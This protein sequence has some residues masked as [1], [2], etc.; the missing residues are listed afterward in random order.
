MRNAVVGVVL[1]H[2]NDV[3]HIGP[4]IYSMI[5]DQKADV[6]VL[7]TDSDLRS[8][9]LVDHLES[10]GAQVDSLAKPALIDVEAGDLKG[11]SNSSQDG[12]ARHWL[13]SLGPRYA[14]CTDWNYTNFGL[15]LAREARSRGQV[16]VS[17]PHG[18]APYMNR[19]IN[20]SDIDGRLQRWYLK[21]EAYDH[22][23]VPNGICAARYPNLPPSRL[24]V[25]GSPRFNRQWLMQLADLR[26]LPAGARCDQE[27]ADHH[28]LEESEFSRALGGSRPCDRNHR[29]IWSGGHDD[30][31]P[32]P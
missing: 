24:H 5:V 14:L 15:S 16:S 22:T 11:V 1:R 9:P 32:Y 25:L 7:L 6:Y 8:L 27:T 2:F 10:L 29:P 28:V 23:V 4:V 17:L 12:Q 20:T 3:D 18:D 13:D 31:T 30:Q 26:P 21:A 19:M